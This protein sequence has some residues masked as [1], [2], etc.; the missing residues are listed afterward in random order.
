MDTTIPPSPSTK[1]I[2]TYRTQPPRALQDV[3]EEHGLGPNGALVYCMEY[4]E[5]NVDWLLGRLEA[6]TREKGVRY[7]LFD[8][9]GQASTSASASAWTG[10]TCCS[11]AHRSN[12]AW[13]IF[14]APSHQSSINRSN[15][16][17]T[18]VHPFQVELYTHG[19]TVQRI[20]KRLEKWGCRLAAVHLIDA[21]HCR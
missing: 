7:L 9:P 17:R 1:P 11:W 15:V 2:R 12:C 18:S 21:H 6:V 16:V 5:Q 4:L 3:M 19:A 14:G 8:F 20:L 10:W 13:V